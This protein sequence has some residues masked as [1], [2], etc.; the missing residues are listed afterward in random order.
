MLDQFAREPLVDLGAALVLHQVS[1]IVSFG[2]YPDGR[3][4]ETLD[5]MGERLE[6]SKAFFLPVAFL[7]QCRERETMTPRHR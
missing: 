6:N 4:I 7:P 2:E 5:R 1:L 3:G